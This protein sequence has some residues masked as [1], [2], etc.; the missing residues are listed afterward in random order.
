MGSA[1]R[2]P[3]SRTPAIRSKHPRNPPVLLVP[4]EAEAVESAGGNTLG[5]A[6]ARRRSLKFSAVRPLTLQARGAERDTRVEAPQRLSAMVRWFPNYTVAAAASAW[7]RPGDF[8]GV[9]RMTTK[10]GRLPSG[11]GRLTT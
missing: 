1:R 2:R 5:G 4:T 6:L 3:L 10:N 9:C 11:R 8:F 7:P